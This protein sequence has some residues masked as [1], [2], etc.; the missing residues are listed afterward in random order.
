MMGMIAESKKEVVTM[1]NQ[2]FFQVSLPIMITILIA[3]WVNSHGINKGLLSG[4]RSFA[5]IHRNRP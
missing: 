2:P 1:L 3:V 4:R 5:P